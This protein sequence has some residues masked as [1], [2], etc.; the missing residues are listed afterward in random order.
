MNYTVKFDEV[1]HRAWLKMNVSWREKLFLYW[2]GWVYLGKCRDEESAH[3][4][5]EYF[6]NGD[7]YYDNRDREV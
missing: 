1:T 4:I 2:F 7:G 3:A 6:V 5:A